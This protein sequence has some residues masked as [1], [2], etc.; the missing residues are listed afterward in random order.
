MSTE[1]TARVGP[2]ILVTLVA[3]DV[4]G[5]GGMELQLSKLVS[6]LLTRG[7]HVTVISRTLAVQEHCHLR[8]VRVPGPRRPF[9]IAYPSFVAFAS[10]ILL[11][12][13]RGI[14]HTTGAM[15][16][17]RTHL[18]TI[19]YLHNGIGGQINR[20][21]SSS[22]AYRINAGISQRLSRILERVLYARPSRTQRL[23]AV[24]DRLAREVAVMFPN[25]AA[26]TFVIPNGVEFQRFSQ[27][28]RRSGHDVRARLGLSA[29]ANV[30]VFVGSE[31]RRKGLLI[32]LEALAL[33][34]RWELI[35]VGEGDV[36]E[37]RTAAKAEGVLKRLHLVGKSRTPEFYYAASDAFVL[38]SAYE[39]FSL[40]AFEA[41]AASLPIVAT[42]VGAVDQILEGGGG[43]A[44]SRNPESIARALLALEDR[45]LAQ[46]IGLAAS[47]V[48]QRFDWESVV[49]AYHDEYLRLVSGRVGN[50]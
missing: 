32:L 40:V 1:Q 25:R 10:L 34:E 5:I 47:R 20:S 28:E 12:H 19:H 43:L 39:T 44:I 23:V 4:G 14:V 18:C 17:N 49:G 41:A 8:W 35:V 48:A 29:E 26:D 30:A 27:P 22:I 11:R 33:A 46:T 6:G 2:P 45:H 9:T 7:V 16:L 36:A 31:W 13:R 3:H 15:V 38:P 24:S 21:R 42:N 50:R 37:V